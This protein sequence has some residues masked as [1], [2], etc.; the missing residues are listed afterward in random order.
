MLELRL[1]KT[2]LGLA[3]GTRANRVHETT[4]LSLFAGSATRCFKAGTAGR[5]RVPVK[6]A[7]NLQTNTLWLSDAGQ[8]ADV[9]VPAAERVQVEGRQNPMKGLRPQPKK[10]T[11]PAPGWGRSEG[12]W[13]F[14]ESCG[15]KSCGGSRLQ[16]EPANREPSLTPA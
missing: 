3:S 11:A 2:V 13:R 7:L 4:P 14:G 12:S 8:C 9:P 5:C 15:Q 1:E 6:Q 10:R 16:P